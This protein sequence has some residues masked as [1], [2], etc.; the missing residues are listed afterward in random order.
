MKSFQ[1]LYV[2][3][4]C[5]KNKATFNNDIFTLYLGHLDYTL[6]REKMCYLLKV[7]PLLTKCHL[8]MDFISETLLDFTLHRQKMCDFLKKLP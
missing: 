3:I 1:A 4:N 8:I 7:L 6:N 2:R 5:K